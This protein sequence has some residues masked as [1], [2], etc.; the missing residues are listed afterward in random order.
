MMIRIITAHAVTKRRASFLVGVFFG[1]N[2]G[3]VILR[4][5]RCDYAALPSPADLPDAAVCRSPAVRGRGGGQE[6]RCARR[7]EIR[8]Q[9]PL[10]PKPTPLQHCCNMS[11]R[12]KKRHRRCA[13][14]GRS[15]L[16]AS[17]PCSH[18]ENRGIR[19]LASSSYQTYQLVKSPA[20]QLWF[21]NLQI[22]KHPNFRSLKRAAATVS[23]RN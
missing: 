18:G 9:G 2:I 4:Y 5:R 11:R 10:S 1:L 8:S 3:L 6:R 19:V 20:A 22:V 7:P 16:M 15:V 21:M 17:C 23:S 14:E 12:A 13:V